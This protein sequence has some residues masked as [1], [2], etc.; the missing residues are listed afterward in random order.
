M[1]PDVSKERNASSET[2]KNL[3]CRSLAAAS[4][5]NFVEGSGVTVAMRGVCGADRTE[6]RRHASSIYCTAVLA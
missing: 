1:V 2:V 3:K 5:N 6:R 4:L